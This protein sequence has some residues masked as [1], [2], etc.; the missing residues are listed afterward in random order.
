M[1]FVNRRCIESLG[2]GQ[3]VSLSNRNILFTATNNVPSAKT[4]VR[5]VGSNLAN[6]GRLEVFYAR[7][8]GT[9]C[10]DGFR[11]RSA[12]VVCKELGFTYV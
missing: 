6:E 11:Q 5:L 8:W 3:Y 2:H 10:D 7:A 9:V 4:A 12:N 1:I